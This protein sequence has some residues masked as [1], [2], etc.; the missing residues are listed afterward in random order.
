MA[1]RIRRAAIH[2]ALLSYRFGAVILA[3]AINAVAG[4]LG[5]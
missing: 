2:H 5:G 3:V 1:K 4:L